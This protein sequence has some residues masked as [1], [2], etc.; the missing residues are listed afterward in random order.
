M[1]RVGRAASAVATQ[2]AALAGRLRER[3]VA[4]GRSARER[5]RGESRRRRA[6]WMAVALLLVAGPLAF[7]LARE[8]GYESSVV[9]FPRPI[10]PYPLILDLGYYRGLLDDPVLREQMRLNAGAGTADFGDVTIRRGRGSNPIVLSV[11]APT[12]E[13]SRRFVNALAP[14]IAGATQRQLARGALRDAETVDERL[15]EAPAGPDRRRLQGRSRRLERLLE[16][17]PTRVLPG[18]PAALPRI[19][20]WA[21]RLV[22][23]LPGDFPARPSPAWAAL[24]GL[25]VV[26]TLWAIGLMLVPPRRG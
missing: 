16:A 15:L 25:L 14:Q 9:L 4:L 12:P 21:D 24:A 1:S 10:K 23:D 22:D 13:R 11:E 17:P 7:N 8:S 18:A 26:A 6:G 20:G 3:A 19:E 5:A 2:P